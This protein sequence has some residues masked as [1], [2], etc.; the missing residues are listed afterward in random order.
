MDIWMFLVSIHT[1]GT[2]LHPCFASFF[3]PF[4]IID[5]S[6]ICC[7]L[8]TA[9]G[10]SDSRITSKKQMSPG[11][12]FLFLLRDQTFKMLFFNDIV[13][14]WI[15]KKNPNQTSKTLTKMKCF[16]FIAHES[17]DLLWCLLNQCFPPPSKSSCGF[18]QSDV[19]DLLR[20]KKGFQ[21]PLLFSHPKLHFTGSQLPC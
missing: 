3:S 1:R 9:L 5:V 21:H 17:N 19:V 8:N 12:H 20:Y 4:W 2:H 13:K 11:I 15:G 10:T 14:A 18:Q 7:R 16:P 6:W